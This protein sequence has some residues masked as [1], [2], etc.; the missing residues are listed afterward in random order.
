[1][2]ARRKATRTVAGSQFLPDLS[3][4]AVAKPLR[5][6]V[7]LLPECPANQA[8]VC[9]ISFVKHTERIVRDP[10]DPTST[11]R[12]PVVGTIG[13]LDPDRAD[14]FVQAMKRQIVRTTREDE[15]GRKS[16]K[17]IRIPSAAS[18]ANAKQGGSTVHPYRPQVGDEPL[19][20][21][22]YLVVLE[23]GQS[24]GAHYPE[25]IEKTGIEFPGIEAPEEAP[26]LTA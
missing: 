3:S 17:N 6:W 5:C 12:V 24:E 26:A 15:D 13:F 2:A 20:R 10:G 11:R 9:G 1:M 18:I 7:G 21:Y 8:D 22:A 14:E 23:D 4:P 25:P 16:G 19:A